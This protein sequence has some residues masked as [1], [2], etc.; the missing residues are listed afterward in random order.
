VKVSRSSSIFT[1]SGHILTNLDNQ[2]FGNEPRDD[3]IMRAS[4]CCHEIDGKESYLRVGTRGSKFA[5][6][7]GKW[8]NFPAGKA[9]FEPLVPTR[10]YDSLPSIS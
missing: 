7:A 6:P 3:E 8:K 9:N 5:L 4:R 10:K 1:I 2:R